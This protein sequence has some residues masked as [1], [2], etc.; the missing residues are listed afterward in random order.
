MCNGSN[1]VLG[2]ERRFVCV[3][4]FGWWVNGNEWEEK[5]NGRKG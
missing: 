3:S 1:S 5:N 4:M 2:F